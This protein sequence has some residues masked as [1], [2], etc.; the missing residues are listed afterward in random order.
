M[1][2]GFDNK[3]NGVLVVRHNEVEQKE[4]RKDIWK[5]MQKWEQVMANYKGS[6]EEWKKEPQCGPE[7][8]CSIFFTSGTT[9]LPKGVLNTHRAFLTNIP[10]STFGR[11]RNCLRTGEPLPVTGPQAVQNVSLMA[12]PLF[13]VMGTTTYLVVGSAAGTKVVLMRKWDKVAAAKLIDR[14]KVTVLAGVPYMIMD[15]EDGGLSESSRKPVIGVSFGGASAPGNL[16][17]DLQKKFP[18]ALLGLPCP[19]NDILIVDEHTLTALPSGKIG[20]IWIRGPNVLKCYWKDP[21]ATDKAITKDGWFRSGDLGY[22]DE[23]GFLY[24]KDRLK[25]IIIRG[26]E[27]IDS[28]TVENA[29]YT[30]ERVHDCAAV[31]VPDRKL[32]EL[33]AL[34]VVLK[35]TFKKTV[36][37]AQLLEAAKDRLPSF[38]RPVMILEVDELPRNAAGK[39]D[40]RAL[41]KVM[42]KAWEKKKDRT[43]VPK[44]KL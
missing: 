19:V 1:S 5:S 11:A 13:H 40:K 12:N 41:R 29:F 4:L 37:E 3:L 24:I 9:G 8:P 16:V 6:P 25:D 23:E 42:K 32:G 33:V 30:D 44:S 28:T 7:D 31:G 43:R 18:D 14:E 15:L 21:E 34:A 27:N 26:G 17:P 39:T 10:N 36:D 2:A 38:A 22:V 35:D 20:E